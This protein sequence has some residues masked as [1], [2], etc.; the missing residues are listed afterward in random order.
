MCPEL[1]QTAFSMLGSELEV[2]GQT[3]ERPSWRS[4]CWLRAGAYW[5]AT[6]TAKLS[7]PRESASHP[8]A[9]ARSACACECTW[10]VSAQVCGL[11]PS[12]RGFFLGFQQELDL[13]LEVTSRGKEPATLKAWPFWSRE[14]GAVVWCPERK[15]DHGVRPAWLNVSFVTY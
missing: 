7:V 8:G 14:P 5:A 11:G 13:Q 3:S 2:G 15:E 10:L 12:P 1:P 4:D 6:P 9:Q